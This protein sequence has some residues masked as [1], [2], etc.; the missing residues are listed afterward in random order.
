M[1]YFIIGILGLSFLMATMGMSCSSDHHDVNT[2]SGYGAGSNNNN[3]NSN[4]PGQNSPV[5]NPVAG[6]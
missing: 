5:T 6:G 4:N 1:K 2:Y 3:G